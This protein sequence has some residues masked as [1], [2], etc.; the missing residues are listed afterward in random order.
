MRT[1]E[2]QR[3]EVY[4]DV[5]FGELDEDA[6]KWL[7]WEDQEG[8]KM[9]EQQGKGPGFNN[10]IT[11]HIERMIDYFPTMKFGSRA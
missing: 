11:D 5:Y 1:K 10:S 3:G 6:Q 7:N 4:G 2:Y 8:W 9:E